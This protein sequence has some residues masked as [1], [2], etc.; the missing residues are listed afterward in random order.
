MSAPKLCSEELAIFRRWFLVVASMSECE[1]ALHV[2]LSTLIV[3]LVAVIVLL[4]SFV[5]H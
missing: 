4:K 5:F 1:D 2:V 3:T